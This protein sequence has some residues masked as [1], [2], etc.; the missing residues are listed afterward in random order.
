MRI[1]RL[2][3]GLFAGFV[4][5]GLGIFFFENIGRTLFEE[6][7]NAPYDPSLLDE[8]VM[9]LPTGAFIALLLAH[10]GWVFLGTYT[11]SFISKWKR[12]VPAVVIGSVLFCFSVINAIEIQHPIWY[13]VLDTLL[14]IP[15]AIY[16]HKIYLTIVTDP[17]KD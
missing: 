11:A 14:V 3:L 16:A 1:E 8:F 13:S 2:F 6:Y 7:N 5:T 4:V 12:Y 9:S 17:L 10:V 15:T